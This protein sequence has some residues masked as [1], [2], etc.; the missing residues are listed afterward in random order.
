M[1]KR[2]QHF[3]AALAAAV[4]LLGLG[5]CSVVQRS[6][7]STFYVLEAELPKDQQP[8][9]AAQ[10]ADAPTVGVSAVRI[11]AFL[12]RPQMTLRSDGN[13][14][15]FSEFSR[16]AEPLAD[17]VTR[18]LR[19]NLVT[20]LGTPDTALPWTRSHARDFNLFVQLEDLCYDRTT[21]ELEAKFSYRLNTGKSLTM[22]YTAERTYTASV[23]KAEDKGDKSQRFPAAI[24]G[25]LSEIIGRL[26]VDIA[27]DIAKQEHP[28]ADPEG[29]AAGSARPAKGA[30]GKAARPAKPVAVSPAG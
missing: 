15:R 9:F 1:Q 26:S 25:A 13:V 20:L 4:L 5:G 21:R 14:V 18:T 29:N 19:T 23:P 27:T 12:D 16:W 28:A 30:A 6:S 3:G 24:A 10:Q 17:G 11:V 2:V 8:L 22:V 7:P